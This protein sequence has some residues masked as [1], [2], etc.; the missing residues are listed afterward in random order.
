VSTGTAVVHGLESKF[1]LYREQYMNISAKG[2]AFIRDQEGERLISYKDTRGIMTIGVGHTGMVNGGVI[3]EGQYIT[4]QQSL[5]LLQQDLYAVERCIN[6]RVK[7][8]LQQ[9]QY[10]ALCSLVFNIGVSGFSNSTLLK[11][12]NA[13]DFSASADAILMWCRAGSDPHI[14]LA[15]R[16]RERELFLSST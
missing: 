9:N 16:K 10:D 8:P 12:L 1:V 11:K 15:R 14:L 13:S 4:A 6:Q 3:T 5:E 7:V 2:I